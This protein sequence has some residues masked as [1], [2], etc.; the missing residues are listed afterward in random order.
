[1]DTSE[2]TASEESNVREAI[3]R[4]PMRRGIRRTH[5]QVHR[6][7]LQSIGGTNNIQG[8]AYPVSNINKNYY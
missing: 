1:M 6:I 2:T 4:R 8:L 7:P 3:L 5:I